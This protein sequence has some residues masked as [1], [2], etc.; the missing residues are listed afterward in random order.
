MSALLGLPLDGI[1]GR[2]R[3]RVVARG[4][5]FFVDWLYGGSQWPFCCNTQQPTLGGHDNTF[6]SDE[7]T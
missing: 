4:G 3:S 6:S 5:T 2:Y 7:R 1:R